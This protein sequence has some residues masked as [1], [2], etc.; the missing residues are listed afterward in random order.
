MIDFT[1]IAR[2]YFAH[3]LQEI[4]RF[5]DYSES[6]QREQLATLLGCASYTEYGQKYRFP[7]IRGYNDFSN[8]LPI[9][10]YEDL[11]PHIQR[12]IR[13]EKSI[14]WPGR[15]DKFAQSSGTSDGKSKYIPITN[16]A[17]KKNHYQGA[18]DVVALYLNMN[19]QSRIFSG[20]A[21]ILGGSFA[22]SVD[23]AAPGTQIGDLSA[24]LI[25]NINP[26][27]NMMRVP[28]KSVALMENWDEKLPALVAASLNSNITNISGVPSWFLTVIREVMKAAGA[29][30]IH[31]VWPNLEVFFHGGIS[32]D[33]YR[34]QYQSI[35]DPQKMH[36]VETYNA[37]EGFFASQSSFD[38]NAMLL[39]LDIGV[40]YEF[41][42]IDQIDEERPMVL[43]LW[44][45]SAGE[46][47]A[48]VITS[49]NGLWRYK[50][51]DTVYIESTSPLKI[52]IAGRTKSYIN[53]FG[54]ELMVHNANAAIAYACAVTSA[55]IIDFTAAPVYT[56]EQTKGHHQWLIEFE[57]M[58]SSLQA[59]TEA[60]DSQLQHENSDYEA[61]RYND[62][63]L[64]AP[65]VVV[66]KRGIFDTWLGMT[67]KRGGQRKVP[68]L[69]NDRKI[70]NQLLELNKKKQ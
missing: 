51:G 11:K 21:F 58:P 41:I 5:V 26:M 22:N 44:E 63:F 68:R 46:T 35:T 23:Y 24:S 67:G 1:P 25:K 57:K 47:Y 48:L 17:L 70:I 34:E 54:E 20:K 18:S 12:M 15:V 9:T 33:P 30:S 60:L 10:T 7:A 39:L 31:D 53:A 37:S 65:D 29:R 45:I 6:V 4:Q 2:Q 62:I 16:D 27:A 55:Q 59:F 14:L 32:F 19:P 64:A 66:A 13:G 36:F 49:C 61:K 52:R 56:T 50:I 43:P 38:T 42:P 28:S 8:T 40:F 3:R 69:C